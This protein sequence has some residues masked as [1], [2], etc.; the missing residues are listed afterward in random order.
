MDLPQTSAEDG[1]PAKPK[2]KA[3]QGQ[4][5]ILLISKD[6]APGYLVPLSPPSLIQFGSMSV[7]ML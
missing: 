2:D 5:R 1:Q 3:D 6:R 4:Q 7:Q